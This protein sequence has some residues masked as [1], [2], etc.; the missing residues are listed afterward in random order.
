MQRDQPPHRLDRRAAVGA[1]ETVVADFL[2]AGGQDVLEEAAEELHRVQRHPPRPVRAD[3]AIGER[4]LAVV[5]RDDAM[6]ADRHAEDI[7]R[8]DTEAGCGHRPR[9]AS[10]PPSRDAIPR[11]RP[12]SDRPSRV[13]ASRNLARKIIDSASTGT[14]KLARDGNQFEPSALRPPPGTT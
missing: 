7:R 12:G 13:R 1:Q 2:E 14:K 8:R 5:T 4:D 11:G 9:P 3:T 6:V 10:A